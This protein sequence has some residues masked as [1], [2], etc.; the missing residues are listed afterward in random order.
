MMMAVLSLGLDLDLRIVNALK[1]LAL[2][3][4]NLVAGLIFVFVADLDY[5]A[6]GLLAMAPSSA[7][8]SAPTSA[9]CSPPTLLRILVVLA[10]IVAAT[11]AM[12]SASDRMAPG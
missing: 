10:G 4:A 8:T 11:H 7:A 3:A 12:T 9:A 5:T 2:L 6:A 1:T